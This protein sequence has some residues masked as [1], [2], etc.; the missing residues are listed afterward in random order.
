MTRVRAQG[1]DVQLLGKVESTYGTAP[2]GN[3]R[4]LVATR[5]APGASKPLGYEP[6]LGRGADAQDPFYDPISMS[7]N[8]DVHMRVREIG[9]WL[10]FLF[11]APTTTGAGPYTHVFN[12]AGELPSF[13]L[14]TG[15]SN[16]TTNAVYFLN[17]GCKLGGFSIDLAR[18]GVAKMSMPMMA[19]SVSRSTS[20]SGGTPV[21]A[22]A[23]GKYFN[24][25]LLINKD[26]GALAQLTG[27]NIN[28]SNGLEAVET[29]G[30]GDGLV[31]GIDETERTGNGS[32]NLRLTADSTLYDAAMTNESAMD[33]LFRWTT[34]IS[35][36]YK[37][38]LDFGRCFVDWTQPE[39]SGAGGVSVG[40]NWR[41]AKTSSSVAMLKAT[42]INDISSY[43]GT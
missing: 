5:I 37:L 14:Q 4:P 8:L 12:S 32:I 23:E 38:D 25:A 17:T 6:E 41:S 27:G 24:K 18:S 22:Y 3:W 35:G 16:L 2:S 39:V 19:Q 42:L 15:W 21:T 29:I 31:E 1:A 13:S 34:P 30:R 10:Y 36:S 9:W 43:A 40:L 28:F 20:S 33:L 26:G 7:G 11:G